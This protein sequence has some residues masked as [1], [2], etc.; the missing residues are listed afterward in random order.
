M[1]NKRLIIDVIS[2]GMIRV[3]SVMILLVILGLFAQIAFTALPLFE[4]PSSSV[5]VLPATRAG[6]AAELK[7]TQDSGAND[8]GSL[9]GQIGRA[10]C[11]E[12]VC[13]LV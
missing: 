13:R 12:R 5:D 11:R 4:S 10:S 8:A 1:A 6:P 9:P 7:V 3:A 2:A